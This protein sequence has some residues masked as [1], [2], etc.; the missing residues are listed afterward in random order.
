MECREVG[1]ARAVSARG[2]CHM[3][4]QRARRQG[5]LI[6]ESGYGAGAD[7]LAHLPATDE[8]IEWPFARF[9]TGYGHMRFAG[10]GRT[11]HSVS[12][13]IHVGPIPD[14]H[15]VCHNCGNRPCVNPRHLRADTHVGNMADKV[16]Q[17]THHRGTRNGN[18]KLTPERVGYLRSEVARGRSQSSVAHELGITSGHAS[19]I[20][21][22]QNWANEERN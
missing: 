12:F 14:G 19:R 2:L 1:C 8:C 5:E 7:F 10:R 21:H 3:H 22:G 16:T 11:A 6:T 15:E 9:M 13:E 4:Y 20:V 17:G 18:A